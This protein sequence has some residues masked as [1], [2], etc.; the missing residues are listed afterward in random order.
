MYYSVFTVYYMQRD[1]MG[2]CA[3]HSQGL[4]SPGPCARSSVETEDQGLPPRSL[5]SPTRLRPESVLGH[6]DST[7]PWAGKANFSS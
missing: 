1:I 2:Y 3:D 7:H 4:Y 5:G 6:A